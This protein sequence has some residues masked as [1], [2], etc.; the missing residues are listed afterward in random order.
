MGERKGLRESGW[1]LTN[2][3]AGASADVNCKCVQKED[4]FLILCQSECA[5]L[6]RLFLNPTEWETSQ[7]LLRLIFLFR[8]LRDLVGRQKQTGETELKGTHSHHGEHSRSFFSKGSPRSRHRNHQGC[9]L[10]GRLP[11]PGQTHRP[12]LSGGRTWESAF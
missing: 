5:L 4:S 3:Q 8:S 9:L 1:K 12:R 7:Q 6:N 11:G 10:K 2:S